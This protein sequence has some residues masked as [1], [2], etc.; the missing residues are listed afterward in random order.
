MKGD[1]EEGNPPKGRVGPEPLRIRLT[2]ILSTQGLIVCDIV[3]DVHVGKIRLP[4]TLAL[5]C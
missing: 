4:C 2:V 3:L 5:M 1:G